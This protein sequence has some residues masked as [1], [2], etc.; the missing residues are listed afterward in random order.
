MANTLQA[1][2]TRDA[3]ASR[4]LEL[5]AYVGCHL[6]PLK[7]EVYLQGLRDQALSPNDFR[8][9]AE[10]FLAAANRLEYL[11]EEVVDVR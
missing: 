3:L 1:R 9:L 10:V 2:I 6:S 7:A 4:A 5:N 11:A 8:N